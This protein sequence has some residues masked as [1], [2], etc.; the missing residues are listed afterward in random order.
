[1]FVFVCLC[2][3]VRSFSDGYYK[4][5]DHVSGAVIATVSGWGSLVWVAV[6]FG[7]D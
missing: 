4:S 3:R 1:M 6:L 7:N 2:A 5:C